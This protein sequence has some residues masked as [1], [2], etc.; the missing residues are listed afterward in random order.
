MKPVTGLGIFAL[1]SWR[2]GQPVAPSFGLPMLGPYCVTDTDWTILNGTLEALPLCK[3]SAL[4][5]KSG[6]S[7]GIDH[8]L[9]ISRRFCR[10]PELLDS[11]GG[12]NHAVASFCNSP[13][14]SADSRLLHWSRTP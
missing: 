11:K 8:E 5:A 7:H 13:G 14:R 10:R 2:Y 9:R 1:I 4:R 3:M 12:G 6:S